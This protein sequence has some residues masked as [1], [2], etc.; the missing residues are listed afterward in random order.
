MKPTLDTGSFLQRFSYG[1]RMRPSRDWLF[2]LAAS[3]ILVLAS[4][5]WNAWLFMSVQQGDV[6]GS[7]EAIESFDAK[8]VETAREVFRAR[9]TEEGKYRGEYRFVDPSL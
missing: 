2:L 9:A 4:V 1:D 5:A 7:A 3:V 8:P 6:I